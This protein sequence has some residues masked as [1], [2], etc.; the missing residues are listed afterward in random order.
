[1]KSKEQ[2][3]EEAAERQARYDALSLTERWAG[4]SV[5]PGRADREKARLEMFMKRAASRG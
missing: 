4:L 2:K 3:R 1:M 5:R